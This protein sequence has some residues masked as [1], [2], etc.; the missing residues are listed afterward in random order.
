MDVEIEFDGYDDNDDYDGQNER[1]RREA[2]REVAIK[3]EGYQAD[4]PVSTLLM[5]NNL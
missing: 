3:E 2:V 5:F 1:K 4:D